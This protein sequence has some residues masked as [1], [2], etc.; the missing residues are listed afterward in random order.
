MCVGSGPS[1]FGQ[2]HRHT[3][4]AEESACEIYSLNPSQ[5]DSGGFTGGWLPKEYRTV[6]L[7]RE[8]PACEPYFAPESQRKQITKQG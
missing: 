2:Q 3:P 4:S 6:F 5:N 7:E 8:I 1:A